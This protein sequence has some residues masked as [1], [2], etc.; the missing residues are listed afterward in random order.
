M[1]VSLLPNAGMAAWSCGID[2]SLL[3]HVYALRVVDGQLNAFVGPFTREDSQTQTAQRV[4]LDGN[5][6]WSNHSRAELPQAD[7]SGFV[8]V[9]LNPPPDETWR[10]ANRDKLKRFPDFNQSVGACA[11][12]AG[13]RWGGLAFYGGEG[14]WG[15]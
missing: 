15:E 10:E 3:P 1:L 5:G 8:G 13:K 11:S 14:S 6:Q 4:A 9:C 12:G 2:H 7:K